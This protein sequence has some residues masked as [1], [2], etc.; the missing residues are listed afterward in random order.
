MN[1]HRRKRVKKV[2]VIAALVLVLVLG[3]G[4]IVG[5]MLLR[6]GLPETEGTV[7]VE[8]LTD[9]ATIY[10]DQQGRPHIYASNK[11]DLFFGQ[12]YAHAQDRL[13]QMELHRRAGQGRISE[14]VGAGELDTDI[15]LRRARLPQIAATLQEQST[16]ETVDLLSS[17]AQGI[18]AYLEEMNGVPPEFRLLGASPE[19]WSKEDVFGVAALMAFNTN[20]NW[21]EKMMRFRLEQELE[22]ELFQEMIPPDYPE[23]DVPPIWTEE[24]AGELTGN[25]DHEEK[26]GANLSSLSEKLSLENSTYFPH[27][28]PGSNSWAISPQRSETGQTLFAFDAHNALDVPNLFYENRLVLEGELELYGWSVAGMAGMLDGFNDYLAWGLTNSGDPQDLFLEERHPEDPHRFKYDEEWYEAEVYTEEIE[29]SGQEEPEEVEIV[30]TRNGPLVSEDPPISLCWTAYHNEKGFDGLLKMNFARSWEEFREGMNDYPMPTLNLTYADVEGNIANR[31]I[32]YIPI[33]RKG[34]GTL[35]APGWDPDYGWEGFIPMEDL[36]KLF[37]PPDGYV[38]AANAV[39]TCEE[40]PHIIRVDNTPGYRMLRITQVLEEDRKFSL[41]DMKQL[42]TDWY[43]PHAERRLPK[44]L[45]ALEEHREE[46]SAVEVDALEVLEEWSANPV[47]Q[48]DEAGPVIFEGWYLHLI[49]EIYQEEMGEELYRD[50]LSRQHQVY[51]NVERFL[52][53]GESPW[54]RG[55]PEGMMVQAFRSAVAEAREE[56]GDD[57]FNWRWDE[58]QSISYNHDVGAELGPL[59]GIF[60]RGPY[61]WGGG[62]RTVGRAAY[63]LNQPYEV[64]RIPAIRVVAAMG[65]TIEA[66]GSIPMGQSGHPLSPH[67]DDQIET[68]MAGEYYPITFGEKLEDPEGELK[69]TPP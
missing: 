29:V 41:E 24:R 31:P 39:P 55:D 50:F 53:R 25:Y 11:K 9:T 35:V 44:L 46:L 47:N 42:Q 27:F 36:P 67:Y 15:L 43:N 18:N 21:R 49:R 7:K 38:A 14:L 26:L 65:S 33:R 22:E 62:I 69:L 54:F 19:P 6:G 37:N 63:G 20:Y 2:A 58:L 17:Y 8:G 52:E 13:W 32:G 4:T 10:R 1:S 16:P 12:G 59:S 40:Y 5:Y 61:P 45:K 23:M 3:G 68:W 57:P 64:N 51:E 66:Y 28:N 30:V 56:L 34:S 48:M 60:N